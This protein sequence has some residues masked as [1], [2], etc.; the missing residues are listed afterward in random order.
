MYR[1]CEAPGGDEADL[2]QDFDFSGQI[3]G[4]DART[5]IVAADA[6]IFLPSHAVEMF[7]L[8]GGGKRGAVMLS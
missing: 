2:K 3:A 4:I 7:G 1:P 5:L 8:L 6:D